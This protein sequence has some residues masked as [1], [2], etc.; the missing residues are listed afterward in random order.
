MFVHEFAG[1]YRS[2]EPQMR[3]FSHRYRCVTY[4]ARGYPP[5]DV[6]DG[7]EKYSQARARDDV[8][9]ILDHL[10]FEKAHIVGLSMGGFATLHVGLGHPHRARS[11]VVAGC[12]YGAQPGEEENFRAEVEAAAQMFDSQGAVGAAPKYGD[13]PTRV[14]FKNKDPRGWGEFIQQLK[15]HSPKGSAM[16]LR[17]VQKRRP[18]LHQ[19]VDGMK[20]IEVPT[21]VL[22]GDEDEPC[23][24]ASLLIKRS[25]ST[26]GLAIIPCAGHTINIEEPEAF[27]RA[28]AD[29]LAAVE[30]GRWPRRDPRAVVGGSILG[31]GKKA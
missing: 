5:S 8:V 10:G 23:L 25:I 9:A 4:S 14:Q 15:E 7:L 2:W 11:L 26:A 28:V 17:G 21:L 20:K 1:D 29:F 13:G 24:E 16:T 27:N 6:P 22:T 31:F 18:L 19:L 30:A 12:G 3:F